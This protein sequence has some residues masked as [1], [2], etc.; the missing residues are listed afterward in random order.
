MLRSLKGERVVDSAL[1]S[2]T[3]TTGVAMQEKLFLEHS[4]DEMTGIQAIERCAPD[5][6]MSPGKPVAREFEYIRR[7]GTSKKQAF[8]FY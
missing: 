1:I 5:L 3:P 4:I 8:L 6:P 7:H 2:A